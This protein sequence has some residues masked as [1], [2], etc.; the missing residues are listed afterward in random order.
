M[1]Q[2]LTTPD[3][4]YLSDSDSNTG[5]D[6]DMPALI[7]E[8][9]FDADSDFSNDSDN[10]YPDIFR[11][12]AAEKKKHANKPSRL[13]E[14]SPPK[15][16]PPLTQAPKPAPP[17]PQTEL[18]K[19]MPQPDLHKLP[20]QYHYQC[21]AEDQ[22]LIDEL[23]TWLWQGNL[24]HIT[25]AHLYATSPSVCKEISCYA[26]G[27]FSF[28]FTFYSCTFTSSFSRLRC[29]E[30]PWTCQL[31]PDSSCTFIF[32]ALTHFLAMTRT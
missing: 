17:A 16:A 25:P 10:E 20:T 13:P 8:S 7:S 23:V 4:G 5:T 29:S 2:V 19:A 30:A 28:S 32:L 18:P 11:V 14:A 21:N 22:K 15:Q 6:P 3:R 27:S 24:M 9:N 26:P 1:L 31:I 12:F